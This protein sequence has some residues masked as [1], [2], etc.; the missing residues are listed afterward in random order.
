MEYYCKKGRGDEIKDIIVQMPEV[1]T[2][3]AYLYLTQAYINAKELDKAVSALDLL[4]ENRL[5]SKLPYEV[6]LHGLSKHEEWDKVVSVVNR[7]EE[8]GFHADFETLAKIQGV[9]EASEKDT[10]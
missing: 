6:V 8:Y 4:E 1:G 10:Q 5:M 3:Q 9:H 7:M 2:Q